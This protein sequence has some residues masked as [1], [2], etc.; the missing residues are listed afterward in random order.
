MLARVLRLLE[1]TA[2]IV[3][4][5]F[6]IATT[7]PAL[8]IIGVPD[9]DYGMTFAPQR[10]ASGRSALTV[11]KVAADSPAAQAG[12]L[13][14]DHL[15]EN[16][17][18]A[19]RLEATGAARPGTPR[20][21]D[22]VRD[23]ASRPVA[24]AAAPGITFV[25]DNAFSRIFV[26][27][28][29]PQSVV[30][31]IVAVLLVLRAPNKM[32]WGLALFLFSLG[33]SVVGMRFLNPL[34]APEQQEFV[35]IVW[36][37]INVFGY[38]G[39]IV[40][41]LRFPRNEVR[42]VAKVA[43]ACAW[44]FAAAI[45][46]LLTIGRNADSLYVNSA[47]LKS[48][49]NVLDMVFTYLP[50][51]GAAILILTF[52]HSSGVDR[53]RLQWV[54]FGVLLGCI[55]DPVNTFVSLAHLPGSVY[56]ARICGMSVI[57]VPVLVAY[58]VLRHRVLDVG[59]VVNRTAI[60][61][62]VAAVLVAILGLVKLLAST[63]LKGSLASTLQVLTAIGLGLSTTRLYKFADW[64]V[65]RYFFPHQHAMEQRL[66]RLGDGLKYAQSTDLV[67]TAVTS[68]PVEAMNLG[69]AALFRK[70]PDGSYVR[71]AAVGWSDRD[72]AS[73]PA[74]DPLPLY[75]EGDTSPLGLHA[76]LANR[77]GFPP[78]TAA[79]EHGFP[80]MVARELQ[81]FALYSDHL[82]G[83]VI[84]PDEVDM[85]SKLVKAAGD[86]YDPL[87]RVKTALREAG[88]AAPAAQPR[89]QPD[90]PVEAGDA[91]GFKPT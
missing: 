21:F 38:V 46:V 51:A 10:D 26:A 2:V 83:T 36:T 29:V 62:A 49:L 16:A 89:M 80:L 20:T 6:T 50:F 25:K 35:R 1:L 7:L 71:R 54:I 79:P 67:A 34:I 24:L 45:F 52:M 70:L 56:I 53:R 65:D 78:G 73:I 69:S 14:G 72:L 76:L 84:D 39:A 37:A 28:R 59:F 81:G 23:G 57:L 61:T 13:S 33:P 44:P 55:T 75:F 40:F 90:S 18:Y 32:T 22:L 27:L 5:L 86:A 88:V 19:E 17:S 87:L 30:L 31:A 85:L 82:D 41:A 8:A 4:A 60:Y 12:V 64:L 42:G 48:V 74:G 66:K 11:V 63:Y 9:G 3:M 77:T 68:E 91:S 58:G 43:D 15:P 47:T